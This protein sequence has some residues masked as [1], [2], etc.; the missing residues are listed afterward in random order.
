[1]A[2]GNIIVGDGVDDA[3][4]RSIYLS[5]DGKILSV[6]HRAQGPVGVYHINEN[7]SHWDQIGS[8]ILSDLDLGWEDRGFEYGLSVSFAGDGQTV[9]IAA[10]AMCINDV[11]FR[12]VRI[13]RLTNTSSNGTVTILDWNKVGEM[14]PG[15]TRCNDRWYGTGGFGNRLVVGVSHS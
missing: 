4:G 3:T 6:T 15:E 11:L 14:I 2:L 8:D 10:P 5:T 7:S 1:M 12:L 9:A 13:F